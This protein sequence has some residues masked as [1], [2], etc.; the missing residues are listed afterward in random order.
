M[1]KAEGSEGWPTW[2]RAVVSAAIVVHLGAI[3]AVALAAGPSSPLER[4]A[5]DLALPYLEVVDQDHIHRYYS[6]EP[7]PTPVILARLHY[8]DGRPDREI[9]LPD[10]SR[11]PRLRYQRELALAYHL[12]SDFDAARNAPGGPQG[13]VLAAS[14][15]RHL[16]KAEP[17]VSRVTLVLRRHLI[18]DLRQLRLS[19]E[20]VDP[21][22]DDFY[23]VP[24]RIGDFACDAF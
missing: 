1:P 5:A 8:A 19:K 4:A 11:R 16:C 6:A 12:A 17:G 14:Y 10:R 9:R 22:S 21:D 23:T 24:E 3:L 7:P 18:P 15:A 20:R 2:A 13:S